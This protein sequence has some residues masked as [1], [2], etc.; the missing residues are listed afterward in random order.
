MDWKKAQWSKPQMCIIHFFTMPADLVSR[1]WFTIGYTYT[2]K[3]IYTVYIHMYHPSYSCCCCWEECERKLV[4]TIITNNNYKWFIIKD[5]CLQLAC[6]LETSAFIIR[7]YG[8][9]SAMFV[10]PGE[11]M[12]IHAQYP[13]IMSNTTTM[14]TCPTLP[15]THGRQPPHPPE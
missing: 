10:Y 7:Y 1:I 14:E 11:K 12:K 9:L 15:H 2:T 3:Q 6:L 4:T 5:H 13:N 8:A